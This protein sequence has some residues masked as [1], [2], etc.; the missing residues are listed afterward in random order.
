M[1]CKTYILAF[2]RMLTLSFLSMVA[3][4]LSATAQQDQINTVIGGGPDNIPAVN[5][6]VY[7]PNQVAVDFSGNYYI[8][9]YYQNQVFKVNPSGVLTI[10]AGNGIAG[11]GGDGVAGG[12]AHAM[13][14]GPTGVSADGIGDVYIADKFNC[15]IRE[16]DTS[17][18]ITTIAGTGGSCGYAGDGSP[19]TSYELNL[20]Q[21]INLDYNGN[22]FIADYANARI[23]KLNLST[24]AISTVVGIGGTPAY[25]AN[26]TGAIFCHLSNTPSVA[27][28]SLDDI[29]LT[30]PAQC[31]LYKVSH[32]TNEVTTLAGSPGNCGYSG[33][34]GVS[35]GA[36]IN[37][38]YGQL[39]VNSTGQQVWLADWNNERIR[40]IVPAALVINTV[41]GGNC[42]TYSGDGG[43]ATL[44]CF[45]SPL[46]VVED[47]AGDLFVGDFLNNRVREVPCSLS[48]TS[49]APPPGDTAGDIYSVAGNGSDDATTAVN[50]LPGTAITLSYPEGVLANP[51]ENIF[52]SDTYNAYVRE[53]LNSTGDVNLFAGD[54]SFGYSGD[55]GL[56]TSAE[57][58]YPGG[59]SRDADGNI[60]FADS[61]NCIIR[62]VDTA[63][64]I[65]TVAGVP[66]TPGL[67]CGYGGD[68]GPA[69]SAHLNGPYDVF[70]DAHGNLFIADTGN[71]L[72]REVVCATTGTLT[73]EPPSGKTAGDIY[74]VAGN[75]N[76]P[77]GYH[78][79]GGLATD[80]TLN[81]PGS[82]A[83]DGAGNLYIADTYN[84]RIRK[85]KAAT[86]IISTIAG[87]G[88]CGFTGDGAAVDEEVC[89]AQGIR[90]DANGNVFFA[91]TENLRVRWVD[92]GG[93][94]TTFGGNGSFGF[95]GDSGPAT[96]AELHFPWALSE[97]SSG[98]F[99]V[100]DTNNNRV[101]EINAF[102]AVGRSTGSLTFGSTAVGVTSPAS[103]VTLSGIGPASI[104]SISISGNFKQTNNCVG[105]LPNG[106]TC[107]VSVYFAPT[108]T[109]ERTG[110]L[111]VNT[112]GDL[113]SNTKV[114]LEG[115]GV[116][117]T[118]TGSL[119]F[120]NHLLGTAVTKNVTVT[121][122]TTYS[123]VALSGD[124]TDFAISSNTCMGA[125]TTSCVIGVK[126]DPQ[127]IG[128]KSATLV[129]T[130]SSGDPTSPQSVAASGTGTEVSLSPT[131]L[132]FGTATSG[133]KN[134]PVTVK[135]VGTTALTFTGTP[136]ISG[137]GSAQFTVLP[138]ASPSTSTCLNGSVKLTQDQTCT[139]TVQFTSTGDGVSYT[140]E[141]NISDHGGASP[142]TVKITAMD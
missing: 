89:E 42:T 71:S 76:L 25:C 97:D 58:D 60:F 17:N 66:A 106:A 81:G 94:I 125:V 20:P 9:A 15:V 29:F 47:T 80:T 53:L 105:S 137:A 102:A 111:T 8:A 27:V 140:N 78:G 131:T 26:G 90:V 77:A 51:S 116:N 100:A 38:F 88:T 52:V 136:T 67:A 117:L 30:D 92:V 54:G 98:N 96:S 75:N 57:L 93:T 3:L 73:C 14:N 91:D 1:T 72:V 46:G 21:Q 61:Y 49:C 18:T 124:T 110:T 40:L 74:T 138:Y 12:A 68:G 16:V 65:S 64:N 99:F 45:N 34:G 120:G 22:L 2:L 43:P 84:S 119:A 59:L 127:T 103:D 36:E 35:V 56:A 132:A 128:A 129:I 113:S 133:T 108:G 32:T 79:D 139:F 55:G 122:N 4:A 121:G 28:D 11:Y 112:N 69:T 134:L 33:D 13:L 19:A 126:F 86:G 135:N 31:V 83:T 37:P 48:G 109:G 39:A 142:Q 24:G 7:G 101:R 118:V 104:T 44:A 41:A 85:V 50:G 107:T 82:A 87:N 95:S 5:A 23:R 6:D 70:V 115:N 130:D 114:A 63:G 141:L 10:V 62:E 123:S